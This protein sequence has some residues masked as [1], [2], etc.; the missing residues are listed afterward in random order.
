MLE[1]SHKVPLPKFF[2]RG[3]R[4]RDRS[5]VVGFKNTV[6]KKCK[7]GIFVEDFIYIIGIFV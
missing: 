1:V 2:A 3:R 6:I 5:M 4:G 7:Q